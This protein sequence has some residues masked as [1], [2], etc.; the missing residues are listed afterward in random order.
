MTHVTDVGRDQQTGNGPHARLIVS[1][2]FELR[3][4]NRMSLIARATD[5]G[6][7]R[8]AGAS[9]A[10]R[11]APASARGCDR[12]GTR[13]D[14]CRCAHRLCRAAGDGAA[15]ARVRRCCC[16]V[17]AARQLRAP[18]RRVR[19]RSAGPRPRRGDGAA[20]SPDWRTRAIP[21]HH[22]VQRQRR[23]NA[24]RGSA[25]RIR[26]TSRAGKVVRVSKADGWRRPSAPPAS[27]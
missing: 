7:D 15:L 6:A 22:F 8:D 12:F 27:T 25:D 19:T 17:D 3:M 13:P 9:A 16:R 20:G 1:P 26:F 5:I 11:P 23:G 14:R 10:P 21:A 2:L 18:S 4:L 24:R